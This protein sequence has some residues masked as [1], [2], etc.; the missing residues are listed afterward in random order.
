MAIVAQRCMVLDASAFHDCRPLRATLLSTPF[1]GTMFF[2]GQFQ[3][4]RKPDITRSN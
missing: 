4:S 2:G 1:V 3:S